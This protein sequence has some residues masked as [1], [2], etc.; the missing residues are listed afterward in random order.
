[1]SYKPQYGPE[2]EE[3]LGREVNFLKKAHVRTYPDGSRVFSLPLKVWRP[4]VRPQ[5]GL[6]MTEENA[7]KRKG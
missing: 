5:R 7:A 2:I 6:L 4:L 1:M 3:N